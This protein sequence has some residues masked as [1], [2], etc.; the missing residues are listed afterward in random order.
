MLT[1]E[2][3]SDIH[4]AVLEAM[5]FVALPVT[6]YRVAETQSFDP[7]YQEAEGGNEEW[8]AYAVLG[9]SV[10]V[11]PEEEFLT[12]AGLRTN[13]DILAFIPRGNVLRWEEE[14]GEPLVIVAGMEMEYDGERFS[15]DRDPR[16]DPLPVLLP[17]AVAGSDYIGMSVVGT[18]KSD[19][20]TS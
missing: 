11:K 19:T 15:V 17:G 7:L 9:A 8:E 2:E 14:N 5:D 1:F 3:F 4:N 16:T 18:V 12:K 20:R 13:A 6:F 10:R